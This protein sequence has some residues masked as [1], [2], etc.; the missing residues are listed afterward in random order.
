MGCPTSDT[1]DL[2]KIRKEIYESISKERL[3][4]IA[5]EKSKENT[6]LRETIQLM[7]QLVNERSDKQ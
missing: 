7:I 6:D 5:L 2:N 4:E 3:V 1:I